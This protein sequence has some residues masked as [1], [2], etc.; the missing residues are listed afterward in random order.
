VNNILCKQIKCQN[1]NKNICGYMHSILINSS[2]K[3]AMYS[4]NKAEMK[5][6]GNPEL[7]KRYCPLCKEDSL[8]RVGEDL[9]NWGQYERGEEAA[10]TYK[11]AVCIKHGC[12][13]GAL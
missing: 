8:Y 3:C 11:T 2:G 7:K 9:T 5:A 1:N 6:L 10:I 12:I 13:L 4:P